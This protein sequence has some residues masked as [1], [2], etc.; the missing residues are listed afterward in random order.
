MFLGHFAVGFALK[1]AA[2]RVSLGTVFLAAQFVDLLWPL[3]LLIGWEHVRIDP[4]NTAVTPLDFYDY[5]ITHSLAGAGVL[6]LIFGGLYFAKTRFAAGAV[7]LSLAVE[8]HWF[9]DFV[10]HRA[11]LPLYPGGPKVGLGLWNHVAATAALELA[12]F[13]AALLWYFQRCRPRQRK[14]VYGL[15]ALAAVLVLIQLMSY[16]G[17]P[18]PSVAAIIIAGLLQWLLVA[19]GYWVDRPPKAA[20]G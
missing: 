12:M 16:T 14:G 17:E 7:L 5:P 8:S 15:W 10:T 4:G 1:P 3:M 11:D 13:G 6:G 9:L 20:G 19:W 2:P 18:P